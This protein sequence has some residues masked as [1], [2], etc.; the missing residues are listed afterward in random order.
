VNAARSPHGGGSRR[1]APEDERE[2]LIDAFTKLA[3]EC[4]YA[5][6]EGEDVALA[7]RLSPAAFDEHFRDMRQC[8]LAAYDRFF[9]R[10]IEEVEDCM[11]PDAPWPQQVKCG[12]EAALDYVVERVGVARLFAIEAPAVGPPV[13]DR[14]ITAI[15]RIVSLLRLG[16]GRSKAAAALPLLAE[17]VLVAGAVSLVTAALLAE[18]DARLPE[19]RAQLVE[20]LLMPYVGADEAKRLALAEPGPPGTAKRPISSA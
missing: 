17:A 13:I 6:M 14:Y 16:R 8:L 20:T 10:L 4:G 3:A 2:R 12:V 15:E 11:D 9:D 1:L 7:A 19:L 5:G 18:E